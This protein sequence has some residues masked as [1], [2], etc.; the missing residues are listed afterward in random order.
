MRKSTEESAEESVE[1]S[2][3]YLWGELLI[4]SPDG[5]RAVVMTNLYD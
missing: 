3:K 5:Q 4:S 1:R 2:G